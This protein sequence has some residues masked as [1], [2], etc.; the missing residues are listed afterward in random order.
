MALELQR[1]DPWDGDSAT[2][3]TYYGYATA[4]TGDDDPKWT[5]KKKVIDGGVLKYLYPYVTGDII[6]ETYPAI[7]ANDVEYLKLTGLIWANRTGY[8]Y[9]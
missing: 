1:I 9:K 6:P 2:G 7:T 3:E 4:G 5:I 8:T